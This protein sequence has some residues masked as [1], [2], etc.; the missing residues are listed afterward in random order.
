MKLKLF[1]FILLC[2]Y[3]VGSNNAQEQVK[4]ANIAIVSSTNT[5]VAGAQIFL[6][7][8][9]KPDK[10]YQLYCSN[11]YGAVLV[12]H[13]SNTEQLS[14]N[15]PDFLAKKRGILYWKLI[16]KTE[17][18]SGEILIVSKKQPVTIETYLGPPSIDAGTI[19]YTMLVTIPTDSLDN[20][21]PDNSK[22][23]VKHQFLKA[24]KLEPI[25]TDKL[26]GYKNIYS[27]LKS[28]RIIISSESL[29]LNSKE[30]S[31]NVMPAIATNFKLSVERNHAYA[32]GNQ[33]TTF[34][35]SVIKDK[36]GNIVSDGSFIEFFITNKKGNILKTF[37]ATINGIAKARIIHPDH[38]ERWKVKAFFIGIAESDTLDILYKQV[39]KKYN[40]AFSNKNRTITIGPLESFMNQIIPDGLLI[41]VAIFKKNKQVGE[42]FKESKNGYAIFNLNPNIYAD[43]SYNLI[44]TTAEIEKE[45]KMVKLW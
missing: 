25:F 16:D 8:N 30:F 35:T 9:I 34:V 3:V 32:D 33:I 31:V 6:K 2:N 27:P 7:F 45:F 41:K 18:T 5:Y 13:N 23:I 4:S 1:I 29:G 38:A 19:D 40:V 28:G 22:V 36:H 10:S 24:E 12:A 42:L 26:I 44:I 14:F 43:D 39:I 21:I 17:I 20:P 11:S 15:I 37:G